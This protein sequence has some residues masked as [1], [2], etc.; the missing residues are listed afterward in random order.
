MHNIFL[1]NIEYSTQHKGILNF[2]N[3]N[4]TDA[5][6]FYCINAVMISFFFTFYIHIHI[7]IVKLIKIK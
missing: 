2:Y 5:L 7:H 1:E 6:Y 3:N 4:I